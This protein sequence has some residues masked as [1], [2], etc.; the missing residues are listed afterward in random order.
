MQFEINTKPITED[1]TPIEWAKWYENDSFEIVVSRATFKDE[2]QPV[3]FLVDEELNV[4]TSV[5]AAHHPNAKF[6]DATPHGVR[7]ANAIGRA[8]SL[9][10]K[11]EASDLCEAINNAENR[12]TVRVSKTAKGVLWTVVLA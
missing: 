1:E 6:T 8:F 7:L 5:Y 9:T 2:G 12:P 3:F 10:G 11:V 4:G